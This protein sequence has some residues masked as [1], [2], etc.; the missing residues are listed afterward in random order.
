[1]TEQYFYLHQHISDFDEFCTNALN[2]DLDY[3]QLEH[4]PFTSEMLTFGNN[5]VIFSRGKLGRRMLQRG[6]S[7]QGM[8]TLGLPANPEISIYWR[9]IDVSGEQLFIFP[10]GGELH[11]I[12]Q[13]DF[14]VFVI[15]MTEERLDQVCALF[16]LPDF[17]KLIDGHEVFQCNRQLLTKFRRLLLQTEQMLITGQLD[18]NQNL[19]LKQLEN[20]LAEQL[21]RLLA[22]SNQPISRNPPRKRDIALQ[23]AV[24]Y[25]NESRNSIVT[26]QNLCEV[27]NASQRTLEYAFRERYGMTPKAFT[28]IYRLN[29]ARKHLRVTDPKTNQ[30]SAI[31]QQHGFWH[32]GQFSSSY[33]KLFAELPSETLKQ[34]Y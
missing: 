17:R 25:I 6:S 19:H 16:Q 11:S 21:I 9:N 22:D 10:P 1:M 12:S 8:I 5:H 28:L 33:R 13:A 26:M 7:P 3:H 31:A 15:S 18:I 4:G 20:E 14:D 2:W 29:N 23:S 24:N 34:I 30:V 32:M 27:C